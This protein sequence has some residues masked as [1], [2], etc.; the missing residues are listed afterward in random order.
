[1][2]KDELLKGYITWFQNGEKT[3]EQLEQLTL[4][5]FNIKNTNYNDLIKLDNYYTFIIKDQ[6]K[7]S[8]TGYYTM[9][10]NKEFAIQVKKNLQ[11]FKN[12]GKY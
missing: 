12:N 10:I 5:R 9:C 8:L 3:K 6:D 7:N 11:N 4:Q 2:N 1:M